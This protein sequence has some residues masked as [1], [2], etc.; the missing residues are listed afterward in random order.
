MQ[1]IFVA[2]L[3]LKLENLEITYYVDEILINR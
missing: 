1:L 3:G 2:K